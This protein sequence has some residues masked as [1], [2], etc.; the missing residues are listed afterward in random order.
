[1]TLKWTVREKIYVP[2]EEQQDAPQLRDSHIA[3]LY[4]TTHKKNFQPFDRR[5]YCSI[6]V[7]P[8]LTGQPWNNAALCLIHGLRPSSIRVTLGEMTC[9]AVCWRVT[10]VLEKDNKTIKAISQEVEVGLTKDCLHGHHLR[11]FIRNQND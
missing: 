3:D 8:N 7:L 2:G 4:R 5:G 6:Q 10:V 9:D 11:C 1:M